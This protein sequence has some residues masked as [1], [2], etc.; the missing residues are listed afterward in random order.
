MFLLVFLGAFLRTGIGLTP[1][2]GYLLQNSRPLHL[3]NQRPT[4]DPCKQSLVKPAVLELWAALDEIIARFGNETRVSGGIFLY[5]RQASLLTAVIRQRTRQLNI[6]S[7]AKFH[8]CETG[9]GGGHSAALFLASVDGVKVVS[10]DKCD[11]PYQRPAVE[12]LKR[13]YPHRFEHV[14]GG[15]CVTVPQYAASANR[16]PCD[17]LHGSSFCPT[18]NRDLL[19]A[20]TCPGTVLTST[21]MHSLKDKDVYF[22]RNAQWRQLRDQGLLRNIS[23]W[24]EARTVLDRD[25][26]FMKKR[27]A[28][29]HKFCFALAHTIARPADKRGSG[30][31]SLRSSCPSLR[32]VQFGSLCPQ[33]QVNVPD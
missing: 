3:G 2:D 28:M 19:R 21:A 30:K 4:K 12:L 25:Y 29:A 17:F 32:A 11:R 7:R 23:C 6:R 18:D 15:S 33:F 20:S 10:F 9:F 13:M 31:N 27:G 22:G 14:E 24:T 1:E 8:V 16:P 5:P 26:V